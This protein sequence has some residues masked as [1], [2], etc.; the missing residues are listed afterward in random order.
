MDYLIAEK[1]TARILV[2]QMNKGDYTDAKKLL[3][4]SDDGCK[5]ATDT[6]RMI[7]CCVIQDSLSRE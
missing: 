3:K 6:I 7:A 5:S 4:L 2:D 1:K